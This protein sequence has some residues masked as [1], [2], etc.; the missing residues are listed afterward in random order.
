[1][2]VINWFKEDLENLQDYVSQMEDELV[3]CKKEITAWRHWYLDDMPI[4]IN[5]DRD[6]RIREIF[7]KTSSKTFD[8]MQTPPQLLDEVVGMFMNESQP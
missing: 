4:I 3:S 5:A 8:G 7:I 6:K 2:D 1:M